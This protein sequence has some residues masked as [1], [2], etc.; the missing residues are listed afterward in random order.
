[1]ESSGF[2]RAMSQSLASLLL[3]AP[4]A[5]GAAPSFWPR[6]GGAR[7]A[8]D[9]ARSFHGA[10]R[11]LVICHIRTLLVW[12]TSTSEPLSVLFF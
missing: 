7:E 2:C 6:Y 5:L 1:M 8:D 4:L 12:L 3:L 11:A 10:Y 9:P